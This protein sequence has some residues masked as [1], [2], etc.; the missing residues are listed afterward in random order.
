M[1]LRSGMTGFSVRVSSALWRAS[2]MG[3]GTPRQQLAGRCIEAL[4]RISSTR[5]VSN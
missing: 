2:L 1:N 5:E 4:F 3:G